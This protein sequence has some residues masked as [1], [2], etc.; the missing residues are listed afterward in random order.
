M[1]IEIPKEIENVFNSKDFTS[2]HIYI[3]QKGEVSNI[4]A[5]DKTHKGYVC[6]YKNGGLV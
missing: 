4:R 5:Y 1:V 3:D 2:M 6:V